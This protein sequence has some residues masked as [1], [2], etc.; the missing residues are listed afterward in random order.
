MLEKKQTGELQLEGSEDVLTKALETP[1]HSGRVRAVGGYITSRKFF[2]LPRGKKV[3][4][5][6]AELMAHDRQRDK[7]MEKTK[8]ELMAQIAQLKEMVSTGATTFHSPNQLKKQASI[9]GEM[10]PIKI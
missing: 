1:E 10:K 2:N 5:T 4:I 8:S 7:E 6:K 3:R 9:R